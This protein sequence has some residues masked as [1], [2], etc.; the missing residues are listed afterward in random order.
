MHVRPINIPIP[1]CSS[2]K[3]RPPPK[4]TTRRSVKARGG[5]SIF[6]SGQYNAAHRMPLVL[7]GGCVRNRAFPYTHVCSGKSMHRCLRFL[8]VVHFLPAF[9]DRVGR[10]CQNPM[11]TTA[12]TSQFDHTYARTQHHIVMNDSRMSSVELEL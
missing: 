11:T 9:L 12:T 7:D 1:W 8:S 4:G 10:K 3:G 2:H 6:V 5:D